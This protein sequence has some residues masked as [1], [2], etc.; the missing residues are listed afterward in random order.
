MSRAPRGPAGPADGAPER[1]SDKALERRVKRWWA[2]GPYETYVQVTPGLEGV[3]VEELASGGFGDPA[4]YEVDRGGVTLELDPAEVMRANLSLRTASRVLL[5]LGTFPAASPEMLYDRARKLDWEVQL[6]FAA[7]YALRITA[8]ASNL[9]AGDEVANTVASAVS[10][11]MRELGLYPKPAAGAPLEFHV[12]LQND[13]ATVS[14]DTSGELLH[15]RGF[16]RHVHAAPVRETLAAAMVLSGLADEPELPD[17]I[18]DPFCGSGTL[19]MEATDVLLGLQPGRERGFA[20]EQA[21]WFRAGR[22]REAQREAERRAGAAPLVAAAGAGSGALPRLLGFDNDPRA[23]DAARRNLAQAPYRHVEVAEADSTRLDLDSLGA[24]RG[25]VV[26]NLPYG[27]RLRG[28]RTAA[29]TTQRFLAQLAASR[30]RWR[31][32]LLTTPPEAEIAQDLLDVEQVVSTRNGGL[33]VR[34]VVGTAA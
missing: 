34:L 15:R 4:G 1:L 12:R 16:R 28:E 26:S 24:A 23:L 25:L 18:L 22:W 30:A 31:V 9:Q 6:G 10:R 3:L 19:L 27:V 29:E 21:A 5:R 14:L 11:H 33:D 8:R 32:A 7:S 17:V 13:H 2:G 20:F